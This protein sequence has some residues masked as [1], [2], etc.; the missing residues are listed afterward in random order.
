MI[1]RFPLPQPLY[2]LFL[3]L[4]QPRYSPLLTLCKKMTMYYLTCGFGSGNRCELR[5]CRDTGGFF[6][7]SWGQVDSQDHNRHDS[8]SPG[9]AVKCWINNWK[10][11][12]KI[13]Y[14]NNF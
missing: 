13:S 7:C 1:Y 2:T 6:G 9:K 11:R 12:K 10:T 8:R 5:G 14:T 3:A 4:P